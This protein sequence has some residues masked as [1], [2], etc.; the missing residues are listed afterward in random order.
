VKNAQFDHDHGLDFRENHTFESKLSFPEFNWRVPK[1]N[2]KRLGGITDLK[3]NAV[4]LVRMSSVRG[5]TLRTTIDSESLFLN[6][7]LQRT[8]QIHFKTRSASFFS[9]LEKAFVSMTSCLR[10]GRPTNPYANQ[11]CAQYVP[12][13]VWIT[14]VTHIVKQSGLRCAVLNLNLFRKSAFSDLRQY[15]EAEIRYLEHFLT[16]AGIE[17]TAVGR[18]SQNQLFPSSS[19]FINF[20]IFRKPYSFGKVYESTINFALMY[21]ASLS[22]L[23]ITERG[24]YWTD[25]LISKRQV[26]CGYRSEGVA[27]SDTGDE[28][29]SITQLSRQLEEAREKLLQLSNM[30]VATLIAS[31]VQSEPEKNQNERI[32]CRYHHQLGVDMAKRT[33]NVGGSVT[34]RAAVRCRPFAILEANGTAISVTSYHCSVH[35]SLSDWNRCYCGLVRSRCSAANKMYLGYYH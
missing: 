35:R 6:K 13:R 33:I 19:T 32:F 26:L 9:V 8:R 30:R 7:L 18:I 11:A 21:L 34:S 25:A 22:P 2:G 15:T 3:E 4:K 10:H 31:A 5:S 17:G 24:T 27:G 1:F 20:H 23:L 14:E 12:L 16:I 28:A 29:S